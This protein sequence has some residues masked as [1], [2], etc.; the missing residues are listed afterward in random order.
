MQLLLRILG[1]AF[2]IL[3]LFAGFAG[4]ATG[5]ILPGLATL[6]MG[7]SLLPA[8][9]RVGGRSITPWMRVAGVFAGFLLFSATQKPPTSSNEPAQESPE[10]TAAFS[11][12]ATTSSTAANQEADSSTTP[13]S[14][15]TV[16]VLRV[17][18]GDTFEVSM[19][20][21]NEKVRIVG[22]DA[23][24][25]GDC[26]SRDATARLTALI[27]GNTVR[28]EAKSTE[29]RDVFGRLLR[30]VWFA[31]NDVGAGMVR[32][33]YVLS[34]EK[35]PHAKLNLYESLERDAQEAGRGLW[36]GC[37]ETK[38]KSIPVPTATTTTNANA[39]TETTTAP[40]P[41]LTPSPSPGTVPPP[42]GECVIKG[43]VNSDGV[44]IYH[45]PGCRSYNATKIKPEEG[46]R[47][48]C[49]EAEASAAGFRKAG[50]C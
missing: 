35:Y 39:E 30:Y 24:E 2:A 7:L 22:I 28:L 31:G 14:T 8:I 18:D 47:L 20:G 26:F 37:S 50:N 25:T 21:K 43:N 40:S 44:K 41:S 36:S 32:D 19:D 38:P 9:S 3:F 46:D 29:D 27:D 34:Y 45:L 48:F 17:I 42:T 49:T 5:E 1:W 10:S 11:S 16:T 33:G 12:E 13:A 4:V 15:D 6:L 23:P